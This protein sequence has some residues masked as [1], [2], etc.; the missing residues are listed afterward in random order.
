MGHARAS[1]GNSVTVRVRIKNTP[2]ELSRLLRAVALF[3]GS[4]AEVVLLHSEF[5]FNVREITINCRSPEHAEGIVKHIPTVEGIELLSW[6][7]DTFELHRSGKLEV[8]PKTVLRT[9]D[10]LARAYTPGVARVCTEISRHPERV[11][12]YTMKNNL[13][14]VVTDGSAVL[15]LGTSG[16]LQPCR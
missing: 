7:D 16:L 8:A 10:Q 12:E 5:H 15:G 11:Y 1:A 6:R 4:I 9:H 3:E 13:V 14:A 2:G